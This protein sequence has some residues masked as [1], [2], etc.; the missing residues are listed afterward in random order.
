MQY[1]NRQISLYQQNYSSARPVRILDITIYYAYWS[2]I[3]LWE[4]NNSN[5]VLQM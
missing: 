5:T 2:S 3:S 4:I 1:T